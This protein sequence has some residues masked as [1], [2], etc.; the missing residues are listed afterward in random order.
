MA[1]EVFDG[2][3]RVFDVLAFNEAVVSKGLK[4]S[5]IELEVRIDGKFLYAL[6]ADG[7]I[8]ATPTG[9]TAYALSSGG[10]II[11]P[12]LSAMALVP[13]CPHTFSSLPIR[14]PIS[15][16]TRA[17]TCAKA[18]ASWCGATPTPSVCCIRSGTITTTC[19][20]PSCIGL[21]FINW[22]LT[23]DNG[24]CRP[25]RGSALRVPSVVRCPFSIFNCPLHFPCCAR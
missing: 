25:A 3:E 19:C 5:M 8:V 16:A 20:A 21:N 9:S 24:Q 15:T 7:L 22:Q 1:A 10:P 4:G 13:I 11:H 6:R 14:V 18:I 23:M 12:A 17:S 2:N